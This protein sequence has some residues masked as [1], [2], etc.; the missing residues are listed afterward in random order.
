MLD[1]E[2][3]TVGNFTTQFGHDKPFLDSWF[4]FNQPFYRS[5]YTNYVGIHTDYLVN[6]DLPRYRAIGTSSQESGRCQWRRSNVAYDHVNI[7]QSRTEKTVQY[8]SE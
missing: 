4:F 8:G 1:D 5:F 3:M 7:T 2:L 6:N